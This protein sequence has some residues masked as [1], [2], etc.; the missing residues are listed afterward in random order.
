LIQIL[1]AGGQAHTKLPQ[2]SF[3]L[4]SQKTSKDVFIKADPT[5]QM[6]RIRAGFKV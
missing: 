6:V 1:A 2:A 5:G 3:N 4:K